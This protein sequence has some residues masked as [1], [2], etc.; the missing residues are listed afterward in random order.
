M[1]SIISLSLSLSTLYFFCL[2]WFPMRVATIVVR[3]VLKRYLCFSLFM[4]AISVSNINIIWAK[5]C[6]KLIHKNLIPSH[7]SKHKPTRWIYWTLNVLSL[8]HKELSRLWVIGYFVSSYKYFN[9]PSKHIN[10][11]DLDI[12]SSLIDEENLFQ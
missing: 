1:F 11:N 2:N 10:F 12:C 6:K 7:C 3:K 8:F 5:S 9:V 4:S